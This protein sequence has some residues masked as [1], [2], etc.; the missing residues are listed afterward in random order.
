MCRKN[1]NYEKKSLGVLE[2]TDTARFWLINT[3]SVI[4]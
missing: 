1:D 3:T 4:S 2:G